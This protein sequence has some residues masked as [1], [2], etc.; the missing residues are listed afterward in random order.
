MTIL[1]VIDVQDWNRV[2][3]QSVGKESAAVCASKA[4]HKY[5]KALFHSAGMTQR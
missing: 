3:E 4:P 2:V 5:D 1:K